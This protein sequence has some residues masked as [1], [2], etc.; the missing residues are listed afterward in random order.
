MGKVELEWWWSDLCQLWEELRTLW[1]NWEVRSCLIANC[2]RLE[3]WGSAFHPAASGKPREI[4]C[5]E[6]PWVK[7]G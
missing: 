1:T 5:E 7:S 2:A 4:R 6:E 3:E